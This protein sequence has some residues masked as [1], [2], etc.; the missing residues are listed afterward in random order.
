MTESCCPLFVGLFVLCVRAF[1]CLHKDN[2]LTK[3]V[4]L[5][6]GWA[7]SCYVAGFL[8]GS[9]RQRDHKKVTRVKMQNLKYLKLR[10]RDL[11]TVHLT[12]VLLTN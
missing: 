2:E 4:I 5:Q 1:V 11:K 3:A 12:D 7:P 10:V 9:W 6:L 8:E